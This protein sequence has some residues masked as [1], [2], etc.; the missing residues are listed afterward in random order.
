M[1]SQRVYTIGKAA[2]VQYKDGA[3]GYK[4]MGDSRGTLKMN[5][6][7]VGMNGIRY[8]NQVY[9]SIEEQ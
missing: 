5:G 1:G 4:G 6:E 8:K 3:W 9:W 2:R 7:V